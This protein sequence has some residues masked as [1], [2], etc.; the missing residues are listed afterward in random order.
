MFD[1]NRISEIVE[2]HTVGSAFYRTDP[3]SDAAATD[4]QRNLSELARLAASKLIEICP[5]TSLAVIARNAISAS[6]V[7]PFLTSALARILLESDIEEDKSI[8]AEIAEYID[9]QF[10]AT[11]PA[12]ASV[13]KRDTSNIIGLPLTHRKARPGLKLRYFLAAQDPDTTVTEIL[14]FQLTIGGCSSKVVKREIKNYLERRPTPKEPLSLAKFTK[15]K[16]PLQKAL[17]EPDLRHTFLISGKKSDAYVA[18]FDNRYKNYL[19]LRQSISSLP[20]ALRA[21]DI[22]WSNTLATRIDPKLISKALVK[23]FKPRLERALALPKR[24]SESRWLPLSPELAFVLKKV[25]GRSCIIDRLSTSRTRWV[26]ELANKPH[27]LN[28]L[29]PIDV[30]RLFEALTKAEKRKLISVGFF[31]ERIDLPRDLVENQILTIAKLSLKMGNPENEFFWNHVG[32]GPV[33]KSIF[34]RLIS[35]RSKA[36]AACLKSGLRSTGW[37]YSSNAWTDTIL[38]NIQLPIIQSIL[39]RDLVGLRILRTKLQ[40]LEWHEGWIALFSTSVSIGSELLKAELAKITASKTLF[41]E[42]QR[43]RDICDELEHLIELQPSFEQPLTESVSYKSL[44]GTI[45]N[46]TNPPS[47]IN[48]IFRGKAHFKNWQ[49]DWKLV[50]S[51]ERAIE[52]TL[53]DIQ[54]FPILVR[55]LDVSFGSYLKYD[56]SPRAMLLKTLCYRNKAPTLRGLLKAGSEDPAAVL[57]DAANILPERSRTRAQLELM[58]ILGLGELGVINQVLARMNRSAESARKLDYEY[59]EWTLPKKSGGTRLVSAPSR[60]LKRLQRSILHKIIEPLGE[61]EAAFGFVKGRSIKQNAECHVGQ[62]VV[63]NCDI[64]NCFPSVSWR[65]VLG[66]LRRDLGEHLS[67]ATVSL[68]TDI[69]CSRGAL[70]I[71]APTSPAILNRVLYVT[72][73]YLSEAALQRGAIYSRYADDLTF[74]G[75]G[76]VVS[77]IRVAES[78]LSRIDLELD[79]KKTNIYRRGR[80]QIVTGLT[81]NQKVSVPRRVRRQL[82][83]AIHALENGLPHHWHGTVQSDSAL[84]GRLNFLKD[85]SPE[86]AEPLLKRFKAVKSE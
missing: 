76:N 84:L 74:S 39:P 27:S 81:V 78:L 36:L 63:V 40:N 24:S 71:G 61:H 73:Q 48:R 6:N 54:R 19:S 67:P 52:N 10:L 22:E 77:L 17:L 38:E 15:V 35:S 29:Q 37:G 80:R 42:T 16:M 11:D 33:S 70:P 75:E 79:P 23:E 85:I 3:Y 18:E 82:R 14:N 8:G 44:L 5:R 7:H 4:L 34:V 66:S 20:E 47:L 51:K 46:L 56:S 64:K 43:L 83:A 57:L 86:L 45:A 69:I 62:N 58:S 53:A 49:K 1:L 50:V 28:A 68:L 60:P 41:S 25:V 65:L 21:R 9:R 13:Y 2:Q 59:F 55:Y 12:L 30:K 26:Q 32:Y 72:D 31:D